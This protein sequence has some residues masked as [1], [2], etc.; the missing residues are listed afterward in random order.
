MHSNVP[1]YLGAPV[2]HDYDVAFVYIYYYYV[3]NFLITL[4]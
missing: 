1:R 2:L 3:D 4:V